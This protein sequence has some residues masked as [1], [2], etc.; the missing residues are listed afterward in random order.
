M[1]RHKTF[2]GYHSF[3]VPALMPAKS[4][5]EG[6]FI[7]FYSVVGTVEASLDE[8]MSWFPA[9]SNLKFRFRMGERFNA[10]TFRSTAGGTVN[11]YYGVGDI[12]N[13]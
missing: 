5:F 8:G 11:Y 13:D 3:P 6:E 7:L 10:I 2:F 4:S 12:S 9:V 1:I